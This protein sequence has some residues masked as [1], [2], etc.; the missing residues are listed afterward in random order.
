MKHPFEV[1]RNGAVAEV[2]TF[3][4]QLVGD[5]ETKFNDAGQ[6]IGVVHGLASTFGNIDHVGDMVCKGAFADC[7]PGI[8]FLWQ[9]KQD[10]PIGKVTHLEE[11]REG[12]RFEAELVL[13]V[14]EAKS[15][16]ELIRAGVIT[17]TS[18]GYRVAP[19]GSSMVP[20][21][22]PETKKKRNVRH[23]KKV[24]LGEVSAVTFP[25]NPKAQ[26]AGVKSEGGQLL[27][28]DHFQNF[29]ETVGGLDPEEAKHVVLYGYESLLEHKDIEDYDPE[30]EAGDESDAIEDVENSSEITGGEPSPQATAEAEAKAEV[31]AANAEAKKALDSLFG[32]FD[33]TIGELR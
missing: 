20:T 25:A 15:T 28:P 11:T 31:E 13:S 14:P 9:H 3:E 21:T 7:K 32:F 26:I 6:E 33:K 23:L 2:K 12:L 4:M 1:K 17:A 18:I 24:I 10:V 16:Y 22:D 19:G 8:P 30:S 29:L 27:N 5:M